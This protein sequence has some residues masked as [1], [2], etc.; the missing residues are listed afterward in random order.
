[1]QEKQR[2]EA[3]RRELRG[4]K[5]A[6]KLEVF[7]VYVHLRNFKMF[8]HL[9]S[10]QNC[11]NYEKIHNISGIYTWNECTYMYNIFN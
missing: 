1:M 3:S 7:E 4:D 9:Q 2:L 10:L 8:G 5:M 11:T 6:E